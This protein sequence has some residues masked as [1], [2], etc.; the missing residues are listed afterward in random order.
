MPGLPVE[1][2]KAVDLLDSVSDGWDLGGLKASASSQY[3]GGGAD[4]SV[5]GVDGA[6]VLI[7]PMF[8]PWDGLLTGGGTEAPLATLPFLFLCGV[9]ANQ[10]LAASRLFLTSA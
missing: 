3:A 9:M 1:D 8:S 2:V 5:E 4:G 6:V 10:C 7:V